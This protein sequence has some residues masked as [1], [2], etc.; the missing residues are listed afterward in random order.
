M[1]AWGGHLETPKNPKSRNLEL[2]MPLSQLGPSLE[3][4]RHEQ[5]WLGGTRG[6]KSTSLGHGDSE[7]LPRW[8]E[9]QGEHGGEIQGRT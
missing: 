7:A 5:H 2:P 4:G 6:A 8:Q 3:K 9:E 1:C